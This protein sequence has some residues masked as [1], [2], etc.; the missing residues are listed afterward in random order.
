MGELHPL[1]RDYV[2]L[3]RELGG[4]CWISQ[5]AAQRARRYVVLLRDKHHGLRRRQQDAPASPGPKA[6]DRA[7][8][9]GLAA[10]L[11]AD[12]QNPLPD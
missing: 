4:L 3:A 10:A 9:T 5:R 6:C 8:E 12:N 7:K 2:F 11:L 1:Q